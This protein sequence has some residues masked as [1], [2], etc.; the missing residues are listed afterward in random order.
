MN[1]ASFQP[2]LC[3]SRSSSHRGQ[4]ASG[5]RG[6]WSPKALDLSKLR[7]TNSNGHHTFLSLLSFFDSAICSLVAYLVFTFRSKSSN[8]G[9]GWK[10]LA[11]SILTN[12]IIACL[13]DFC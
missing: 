2:R 1:Q 6:D 12:H 4:P 13:R 10:I 7:L 8:E 9:V 3:L 11:I 5:C